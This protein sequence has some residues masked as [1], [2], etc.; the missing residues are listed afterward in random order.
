[1]LI[2][3]HL[4]HGACF[5][6]WDWIHST[7][8]TET[9]FPPVNRYW[10]PLTIFDIDTRSMYSFSATYPVKD[11]TCSPV[12]TSILL[13]L[14]KQVSHTPFNYLIFCLADNMKNPLRNL[15]MSL[16]DLYALPGHSV[17][18]DSILLSP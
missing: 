11:G 18:R 5:L 15:F 17:D 13:S 4:G 6:V 8:P 2:H 10:F 9:I 3:Q 14:V 7:V 1:M 16:P 12:L